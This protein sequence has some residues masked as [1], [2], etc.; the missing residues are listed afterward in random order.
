MASER[1]PTSLTLLA[2]LAAGGIS[3]CGGSPP[4]SPALDSDFFLGGIQVNE[5]ELDR[6]LDA[7]I[8]EG[9][10]TI[11]VTQY[12]RQGDWD[13]D[14][15]WWDEQDQGIVPEIRAAK[16]RGMK[17]VLILRVALDHAFPRNRFLWHGMIMPRTDE[18]LASW[19]ER[20]TAFALDWAEI[21]EREGVDVLMIA[22]EM[23]SLTSTVA[24]E[25]LPN[26]EEYFLNEEKQV[27]RKGEFMEFEEVI[28]DRHLWLRGREN[29]PNLE[30][31]LDAR[32]AAEASWA[33]RLVLAG[34]EPSI[35][36]VNRRRRLLERKWIE[37]IAGLREVFRGQLG[38][39]ANFDQYQLVTF[40]DHLDLIGVNAYFPLRHRLVPERGSAELHALLQ[41]GWKGVLSDIQAFR[42][43]NGLTDRPVIFTEMGYT[44]R[45][46]STIQPWA[47]TG[48]SVVAS[49]AGEELVV[50]Q[51]QPEDL[52]ERALAA[53]ALY[54][55][56]QEMP[57]KFLRGILYWKLST[58]G[59]HR[60]IE[61]FVLIIGG[62]TDDPLAAELRRFVSGGTD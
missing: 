28:E 13:T 39:A 32:I 51:D 54:D 22:S 34:E 19:F 41:D 62:P 60:E 40:W 53:R 9:M 15:L 49:E 10:N 33:E 12:A 50:W 42:V 20:Y 26:L 58:L 46:N 14:N 48:F 38:Y 1:L 24:L 61:P 21:A 43:D 7:L 52:E 3:A 35:E 59:S 37:L 30:E 57:E 47:D 55:A 11:S 4:T 31:Y 17:V 16:R 23:N 8:A 18:E 2:L 5:P 45:A 36:R 25:E 29:Y 56:H 44:F 6:W 27:E